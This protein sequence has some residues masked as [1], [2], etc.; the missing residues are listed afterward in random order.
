MPDAEAQLMYVNEKNQSHTSQ[1]IS[2][3]IR[4]VVT[5][6]HVPGVHAPHTAACTTRCM[7]NVIHPQLASVGC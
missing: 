2:L 1:C 6:L 7:Y 4:L 5:T 3:A